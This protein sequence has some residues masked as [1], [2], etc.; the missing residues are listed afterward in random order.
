M[1]HLN[2]SLALTSTVLGLSVA[3]SAAPT[4]FYDA[5]NNALPPIA[6][7]LFGAA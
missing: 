7:W 2:R 4:A 5:D 6:G 3:A 1:P